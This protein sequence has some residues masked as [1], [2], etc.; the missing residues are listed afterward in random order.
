MEIGRE[1]DEEDGKEHPVPPAP[2]APH[3]HTGAVKH[4]SNVDV[5]A[6]QSEENP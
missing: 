5:G 3:T 1:V 2:H 6:V 4:I